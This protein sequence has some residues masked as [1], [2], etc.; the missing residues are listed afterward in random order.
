MIMANPAH[1]TLSALSACTAALLRWVYP[2][3]CHICHKQLKLGYLCSECTDAL[4][5]LTPPLCPQCGEPTTSS[6][7]TRDSCPQCQG[8]KRAFH[9]AISAYLNSEAMRQLVLDF[10]YRQAQYLAPTLGRLLLQAW[11]LLDEKERAGD[12]QVVAVPLS[13][14]KKNT[15][16]YN[17]AHELA[18]FFAKLVAMP[19]IQPLLRT[20]DEVS[21]TMLAKEARLKHAHKLYHI[22]PKWT[23][24]TQRLKR[25]QIILIDDIYTTGATADACAQVLTRAG[26]EKVIALTLARTVNRTSCKTSDDDASKLS[27][28]EWIMQED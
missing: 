13:R 27:L 15:R 16:T 24:E 20:H 2:Y 22:H 6:V 28:S 12:W 19:I 18:R 4:P 3:T 5:R 23:K 21:Q 9:I 14:E 10:K 11:K 17:Q 26:A 8:K 7:I 1:S 25:K